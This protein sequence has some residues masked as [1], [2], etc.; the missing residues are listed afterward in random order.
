M[1]SSPARL[2]RMVELLVEHE[3][4]CPNKRVYAG[5]TDKAQENRLA[6]QHHHKFHLGLLMLVKGLG[7][8]MVLPI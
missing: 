2:N 5:F 8:C 6:L 7:E 4:V 1:A 3:E